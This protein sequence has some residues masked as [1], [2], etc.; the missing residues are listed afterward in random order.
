MEADLVSN[1]RP[2][3][4]LARL[5][6]GAKQR[7]LTVQLTLADYV[8]L[9]E[10][11]RCHYCD[12]R[13]PESGHGLDRKNTDLGYSRRNVVMA[14]DACNRI[15]SDVFS[16]AQMLEIGNL[17]RAWRAQGLWN[18]PQRKD[19]KRPGGRP[20]KGDLRREID[21]WNAKWAP[22][23]DTSLGL[24]FGPGLV[25]P[26]GADVLRESFSTYAVKHWQA[27]LPDQ[28]HGRRA[29][30]VGRSRRPGRLK[31]YRTLDAVGR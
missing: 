14:C 11:G 6:S 27:K 10:G 16:Y 19:A 8:E 30:V 3:A 15:K 22:R 4:K 17:L 24:A 5:R 12:G 1:V 18:D 21:E 7:Q 26:G 9:T 29:S 23:D 13:L 20:I 31:A 2:G 28:L 25:G